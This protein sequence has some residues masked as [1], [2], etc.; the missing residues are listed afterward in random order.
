M[1]PAARRF[2]DLLAEGR[3]SVWQVLPLTPVAEQGSP[4]SAHSL[5]AG[6]QLLLSPESLKEERFVGEI[7]SAARPASGRA[8][9]FT[10][11]LAFKAQLAENAFQFS[12]ER[13]RKEADFTEY[14]AR[15]S[16]WLEDYALYEAIT[17]EQGLPWYEWPKALRDRRGSALG[18]KKEELAGSIDMTVFTQYL[19]DRQWSSLLAYAHSQGVRI[20]GDVP[21]YVLHDSADVWAHRLLFK[22]DSSAR[23]IYV[24]GVPPDYFSKTGQRWGNPVYDWGRMEATRYRWWQDRVARNLSQ[25]DSLRL[26]HFRGYVAYWEIPAQETTAEN[27]TW[28]DVPLSFLTEVK[29]RFPDLPFIAEDLGVITDEVRHAIDS[30]GI[31]GMKVLQFAFDGSSTNPHLPSNH[32]KNALVCTGTHDTNTTRGWFTDEADAKQKESLTSYLGR[33]VNEESVTGFMID[34]AMESPADLCIVPMQDL[35]N[36]GSEARMNNPGVPEGNWRW[37]ALPAEMSAGL[38]SLLAE[39]T[40]SYG[41]S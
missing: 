28:V 20:L 27:G 7:P 39:K 18:S 3:Q 38:F 8:V 11:A 22:V 40:V 5:F 37:R 12:F 31:P 26:D 30:L 25:A 24:S 33:E 29:A 9:D 32:P 10:S 35:L 1:G 41:R 15:N 17:R 6:N 14:R 4:Y 36:L 34:A 23:P 2:V 16:D 13:I 21:F 19:F